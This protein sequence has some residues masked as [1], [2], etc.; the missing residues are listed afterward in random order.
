MSRALLRLLPVFLSLAAAGVCA[1]PFEGEPGKD[2]VWIA[3]PRDM[4]EKMLDM[5]RVTPQDY[6]I[7]LG[8]GD[9]RNVIAAAK[10]GARALGVEYNPKMV[11]LSQARAA[12]EGVADKAQ[13]VQGDMY[14][15]DVSQATALILFLIPQNL[16]K[17]APKFIALKPGTRIVSNTYE[18]GGGWEPD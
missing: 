12:K 18:I 17:L 4:V 9:G 5:A 7:D 8:S 6:V 14:E 1:Q 13:F 10:R 2:V 11:E 16:E 15:A 3:S